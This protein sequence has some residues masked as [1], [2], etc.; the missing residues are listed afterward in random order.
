MTAVKSSPP[1]NI[2][3]RQTQARLYTGNLV[4]L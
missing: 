3:V 1:A 4:P 2:A